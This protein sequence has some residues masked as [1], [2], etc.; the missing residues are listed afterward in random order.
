MVIDLAIE[1]D[2]TSLVPGTKCSQ[3][4]FRFK[5]KIFG[6]VQIPKNKKLFL[7]FFS[8][9]SRGFCTGTKGEQVVLFGFS[10]GSKGEFRI[11]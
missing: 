5:N 4:F 2:C 10:T 7:N 3:N 1:G 11:F 6:P 9:I 8:T